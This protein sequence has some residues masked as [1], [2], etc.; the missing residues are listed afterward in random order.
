MTAKALILH[1]KECDRVECAALTDHHPRFFLRPCLAFEFMCLISLH[2]HRTTAD[3]SLTIVEELGVTQERLD[4][5]SKAKGGI[6]H[7]R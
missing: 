6:P 5:S 4:A 2:S 7:D 1:S 3:V